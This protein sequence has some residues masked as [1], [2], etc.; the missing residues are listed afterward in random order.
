MHMRDFHLGKGAL[1]GGRRDLATNA[2]GDQSLLIAGGV[3]TFV[4]AA[5]LLHPAPL[6]LP[7]LSGV[8]VLAGFALAGFALTWRFFRKG[9]GM[10]SRPGHMSGLVDLSGLIVFFGFAAAILSDPDAAVQAL[11]MHP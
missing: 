11:Q 6:A 7:V 4:T 3:L 1:F 5:A 8:L 10:P 2:H 9:K